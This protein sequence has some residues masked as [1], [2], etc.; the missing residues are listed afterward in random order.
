VEFDC[1][2]GT[3]KR[4]KNGDDDDETWDVRF[5]RLF[6]P[7][8]RFNAQEEA[9]INKR[10]DSSQKNGQESAFLGDITV[11]NN[12]TDTGLIEFLLP[13]GD[14]QVVAVK[15]DL[16]AYEKWRSLWLSL[17]AA[18]IAIT[19]ILAVLILADYGLKF[20]EQE[21]AFSVVDYVMSDVPAPYARLDEDGKFLKVNYFFAKL[22]GYQSDAE[23]TVELRGYKYED[24]LADTA[25]KEE[26]R[27]IKEER[28]EGKP[29]RSYTVQ[30]WTGRTPGKPPT[31]WIKVH[32]GD[33]P[34]PHG[35]RKKPG[36]SFGILLPTDAPRPVVV[37]DARL[38]PEPTEEVR[39]T[40]QAR[41][42]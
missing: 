16:N 25:S 42:S 22:M 32:G 40:G 21:R 19:C 35:S 13:R 6:Y 18:C 28:R 39:T 34:T 41:A 24:F 33:V 2:T 30:M 20:K 3:C 7:A 37:M 12:N 1:S 31:R 27:A 8:A 5:M 26:F 15:F 29:Y 17:A 36:Q 38:G 4:D 9:E 14:T 11:L 10:Y 23:A